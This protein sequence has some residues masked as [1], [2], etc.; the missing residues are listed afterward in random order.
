MPLGR[1]V[2]DAL[3]DFHAEFRESGDG[4]G[5]LA[6]AERHGYRGLDGYIEFWTKLATDAPRPEGYVKT[7]TWLLLRG[8]RVIGEVRLRHTLTPRLEE[9]GGNIGYSV[10]ASERNKGYATYLL[11]ETLKR[12]AALGL[13]RALVTIEATNGSS[14]RVAEKCGGLRIADVVAEDGV[15]LR[16]FWLSTMDL[17]ADAHDRHPSGR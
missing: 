16:R 1:E 8:E 5:A 15:L 14:L 2:C 12:A 7:N 13:K 6:A 11:R 4:S 9:D 17:G 3:A 10:R